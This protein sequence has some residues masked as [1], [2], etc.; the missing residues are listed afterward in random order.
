MVCAF[1]GQPRAETKYDQ[2]PAAL[3]RAAYAASV[4]MARRFFHS[5]YHAIQMQIS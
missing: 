5:Q 1:L 2:P 3:A 4:G